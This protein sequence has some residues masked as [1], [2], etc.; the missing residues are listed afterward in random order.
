MMLAPHARICESSALRVA[1][2]EF[3][4]TKTLEAKGTTSQYVVNVCYG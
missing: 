2:D 3:S 1:W 4:E